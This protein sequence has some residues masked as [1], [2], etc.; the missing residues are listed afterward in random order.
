MTAKRIAGRRLLFQFLVLA[1]GMVDGILELVLSAR[2]HV[3][4]CIAIQGYLPHH[5]VL[6]QV[7]CRH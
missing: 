6:L 1:A 2:G 5:Q 4:I 3:G 7:P